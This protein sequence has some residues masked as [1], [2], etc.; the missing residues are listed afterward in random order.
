MQD[1]KLIEI[2]PSKRQI[3]IQKLGFY[4]FFHF[5]INTFTGKEWGNGQESPSL[6]N[7]KEMDA[8]QWVS[9]IKAAGMKGAILT[10]KHHDGFCLWPSKYTEHSVKASPY[11]NG[12]GDI[13]REVSEACRRHG[14][15]FGVYLSPWDRNQETYGQGTAYNDYFVNQLTELLT[16]YG[17]LFCV[18]FDGACGEGKNGKKQ[19]YD[20]D[21]YYK[22]IRK[23]QPNACISVTGPD[24]RWCG[25]EAGD[26]RESEWSVVPAAMSMA[27]KIAEASQQE[28]NTEFREKTISSM[29]QDLGSR[30]RLKNEE[31]LIWY[32]AEVDV[33]IR[34]GWFYHK[35]EDTK[36]RSL[37]NLVDI[38]E[39]SVGGNATLLLNIPPMPNGK[40]NETDVMRLKELGEFLQ[41]KYEINLAKDA[42]I[43]IE[44][45]K[46]Q[47]K[48][49]AAWNNFIE[50]S[51]IVLKEDIRF[52]QR[53][54]KYRVFIQGK[55][56]LELLYEGT[57]IGFRK[58]ISINKRKINAVIVEIDDSRVEPVLFDIEIY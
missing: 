45:K 44:K 49:T 2:R 36:V 10:C 13:V 12:Q 4:A 55:E 34:P 48:I 3:E 50:I 47:M 53:V 27:E 39:K 28:D 9:A 15:K 20:W 51:A 32:P 30:E 33:S 26:T 22:T 14:I 31:K 41:K 35:E 38:Y 46:S 37:E 52:S 1:E 54:E 8:D 5:T 16:Q 18:W 40:L 57:T 7:P 25:N 56:G 11:K 58:I 23:Y 19:D 43:F 6:F 42:E 17:E 29:E 24:V 21:R